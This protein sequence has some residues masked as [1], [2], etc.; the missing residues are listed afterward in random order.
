[1]A[2]QGQLKSQISDE[3]LKQILKSLQQ[4]KREFKFNRK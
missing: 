1:M 2:S 3:Q 4:P